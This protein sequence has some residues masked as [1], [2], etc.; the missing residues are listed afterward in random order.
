MLGKIISHVLSINATFVTRYI[1]ITAV[2]LLLSSCSKPRVD[3]SS[4]EKME[5]SLESVRTSLPEEQRDEFNAALVELAL[6]D[7]SI[8]L[9]NRISGKTAEEIIAD[10]KAIRREREI[11]QREQAFQE[12]AE[13]KAKLAAAEEAKAK[14]TAFQVLRSRFYKQESLFLAEPIIELT[15]KNGTGHAISRAYFRGTLQSPGRSVPWLQDEFNYQIR[16]GLETGET[17]SWKLAPNM[18]SDW[19]QVDAPAD[20]ILTVEVIKLDGADGQTLFD[21]KGLSE[22]EQERLKELVDK[23][24]NP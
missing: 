10:A 9:K 21:A 22:Y 5:S 15:V 12:I 7:M 8:E 3:T 4:D 19:G 16:G 14:L 1:L 17:A 20:A 13:L 23:Y 6:D 11:K 24:G 2:A 18:F